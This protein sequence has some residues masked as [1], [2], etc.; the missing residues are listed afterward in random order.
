MKLISIEQPP[1]K[2]NDIK[3]HCAV[4]KPVTFDESHQHA[5]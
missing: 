3:S 5:V 2:L 1:L 4:T